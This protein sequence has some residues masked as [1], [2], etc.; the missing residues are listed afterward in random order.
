VSDLNE[1]AN[2]LPIKNLV[3]P[4]VFDALVQPMLAPDLEALLS[5]R[6]GSG[7]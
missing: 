5:R 6:V 4:V 2:A 7:F 3:N 1:Q